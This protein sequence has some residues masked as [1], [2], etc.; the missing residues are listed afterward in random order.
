VTA[1]DPAPTGDRP[2]HLSGTVPQPAEPGTH[3]AADRIRAAVADQLADLE[4][5]TRAAVRAALPHEP[6]DPA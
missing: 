3:E 6:G 1:D 5:T 4:A 2:D